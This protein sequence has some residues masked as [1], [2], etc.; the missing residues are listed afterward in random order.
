MRTTE[1][2]FG[3]YSVCVVEGQVSGI[4]ARNQLGTWPT[5]LRS[6]L[7]AEGMF[8]GAEGMFLLCKGAWSIMYSST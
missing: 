2:R 3:L 6:Q 8:L 4:T 7:G 1:D 5:S